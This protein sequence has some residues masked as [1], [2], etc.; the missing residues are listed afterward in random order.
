MRRVEENP[1][2]RLA[3]AHV[4]DQ[5]SADLRTDSKSKRSG[6]DQ[7]HCERAGDG[8]LVVA[9]FA[10]GDLDRPQLAE[11]ERDAE[12]DKGQRE[13]DRRKCPRTNDQ[14]RHHARQRLAR[15]LARRFDDVGDGR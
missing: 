11:D 5:S 15:E 4:V 12:D 8:D 2:K 6:D 3:T 14:R 9:L 7:R 10:A 1:P 13:M